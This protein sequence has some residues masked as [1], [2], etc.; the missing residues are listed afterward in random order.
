MARKMGRFTI[1]WAT[2]HPGRGSARHALDNM[3][4]S[5][6]LKSFHT[7]RPLC[8][9]HLVSLVFFLLPLPIDAEQQRITVKPEVKAVMFTIQSISENPIRSRMW[10]LAVM[11][12]WS[13]QW[14]TGNAVK[15]N[16][17]SFWH[18]PSRSRC[19]CQAWVQGG[20]GPVGAS[21]SCA[22]LLPSQHHRISQVSLSLSGSSFS[23]F[24]LVRYTMVGD[25][26]AGEYN[27]RVA[28]VFSS[29]QITMTSIMI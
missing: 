20:A 23:I 5:I 6:S 21:R 1:G 12:S 16:L 24:E 2:L 11:H 8:P 7:P 13:A 19:D 3:P 18:F 9:S 29:Y 26:S 27:L 25:L 14:Q 22:G 4:A 17:L 28:Q 15:D 10:L